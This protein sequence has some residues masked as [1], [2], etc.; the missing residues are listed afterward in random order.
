MC[1]LHRNFSVIFS[2]NSSLLI[3]NVVVAVFGAKYEDKLIY[4]V[5]ARSASA[6]LKVERWAT[7][8][9]ESYSC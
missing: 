8:V 5:S 3:R 6:T 1:I 7:Y 4:L 9:V 2:F